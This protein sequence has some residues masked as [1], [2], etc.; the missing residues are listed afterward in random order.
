MVIPLYKGNNKDKYDPNS[1]RGIT[2]TS[3][4]GK[5]LEKVVLCKMTPVKRL[6]S[7]RRTDGVQERV[8]QHYCSISS[9]IMYF[10]FPGKVIPMFLCVLRQLEL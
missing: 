1:Y 7:S 2:L 9:Q 10:P 5:L 3:V 6:V 8:W 4:I